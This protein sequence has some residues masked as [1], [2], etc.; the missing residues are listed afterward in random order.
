MVKQKSCPWGNKD[1]NA[2]SMAAY[3]KRNLS[4]ISSSMS[5]NSTVVQGWQSLNF[6]MLSSPKSRSCKN[7]FFAVSPTPS[8]KLGYA[9]GKKFYRFLPDYHH[10]L[11]VRILLQKIKFCSHCFPQCKDGELQ[12][13]Q[14]T[15]C[16]HLTC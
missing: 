10:L 9:I 1:C 12:G 14:G 4:Y 5:I 16:L 11:I 15:T 8:Q 3:C 2:C 7:R 6:G 13:F